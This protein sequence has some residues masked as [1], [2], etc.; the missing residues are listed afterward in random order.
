MKKENSHY[1]EELKVNPIQLRLPLGNTIGKTDI[2]RRNIIFSPK[3]GGS[4][5]IDSKPYLKELGIEIIEKRQGLKVA[6]VEEIA[7]FMKYIDAEQLENL[8]RPLL[9]NN[10]GSYLMRLL[11]QDKI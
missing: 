9:K 6:C 1:A 7:Y 2:R 11:E 5:D 4:C 3:F 10:Y 8:A